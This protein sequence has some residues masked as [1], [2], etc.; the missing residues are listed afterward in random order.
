MDTLRGPY[1]ASQSVK[2]VI[3]VNVPI[4]LFTCHKEP[5]RKEVVASFCRKENNILGGF[6]LL[7]VEIFK[8]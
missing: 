3:H 2:V 6:Y 4:L 7:L 5:I 1:S 8:T